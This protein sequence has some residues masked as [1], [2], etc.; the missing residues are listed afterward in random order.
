MH[1]VQRRQWQLGRPR[2]MAPPERAAVVQAGAAFVPLDPAY[3]EARL[4]HLAAD[5]QL[6]EAP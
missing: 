3:P 4:R 1:L 2:S 6:A 5:A